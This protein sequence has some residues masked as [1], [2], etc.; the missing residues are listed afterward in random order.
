MESFSKENVMSQDRFILNSCKIF[1]ERVAGGEGRRGEGLKEGDDVTKVYLQ[2]GPI[3]EG[4]LTLSRFGFRRPCP[5]CDYSY[6]GGFKSVSQIRGRH[7]R[8]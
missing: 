3:W 1:D 4:F 6:G 7:S 8:T 5:F 2:L